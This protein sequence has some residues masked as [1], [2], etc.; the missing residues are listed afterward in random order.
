MTVVFRGDAALLICVLSSPSKLLPLRG[1]PS[2][3][4]QPNSCNFS[5]IVDLLEGL[6]ALGRGL[7]HGLILPC[8]FLAED[9]VAQGSVRRRGSLSRLRARMRRKRRV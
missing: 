7:A 2:L 8:N 6:L 1:R 9:M 3:V 5:Q 4:P